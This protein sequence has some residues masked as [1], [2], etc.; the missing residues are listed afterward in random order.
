M[1]SPTAPPAPQPDDKDWT[2]VLDVPCPD[3]GYDAA[4][5]PAAEIGERIRAH[6]PTWT[7]AL[8][9]PDAA[10]RPSPQVWSVLEYSCHVRDVHLIFGRRLAAMLTQDDPLFDNWDQDATAVAERYWTQDPIT[11]SAALAAAAWDTADRF[12]AVGDG[13]WI[14]TGRRSNG[15]VFTVRTVGLYYLHD[16]VHHAHDIAS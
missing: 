3:C 10:A 15:S 13:E 11:V 14:R 4:A 1:D 2:W 12:A 6:V 7:A 5:V 16:L 9:A 8:A